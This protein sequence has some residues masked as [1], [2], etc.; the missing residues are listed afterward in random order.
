MFR[1]KSSGSQWPVESCPIPQ[2]PCSNLILFS[3]LILIALWYSWLQPKWV[4]QIMP[5]SLPL[6]HALWPQPPSHVSRVIL[7]TSLESFFKCHLIQEAFPDSQDR[8]ILSVFWPHCTLL[9]PPLWNQ[10]SLSGLT[11][12]YLYVLW[13]G[14]SPR[15]GNGIPF[16][17]GMVLPRQAPIP[18]CACLE[19]PTDRGAWWVT[20]HRV[21]ES[22][23]LS[24]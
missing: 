9:V 7:W 24:H 6:I 18:V 4:I 21:T 23:R 3:T 12:I 22:T 2:P 15:E 17:S 8:I 16:P 14:I 10:K 19:K 5:S 13:S 1:T 11:V 20:V